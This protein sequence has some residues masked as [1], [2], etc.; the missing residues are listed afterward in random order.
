[1]NL[2]VI[3]FNLRVNNARDGKN[4]WPYRVNKAAKVI[5]SNDPD[6]IGMQE[7][8]YSM[9]ED[10]QDSL[11]AYEMIGEG[12]G[13]GEIDEYSAI[14]YKKSVLDLIDQ[15]QF[16][17]SETPEIANSISWNSACPRICT[18]GK[19]RKITKRSQEFIVFNTHLDHM[20]KEAREKGVRLILAHI[21]QFMK[22]KM[23]VI[24]MGDLNVKPENQVIQ[25]LKDANLIE[26]QTEG[27]TFHDF[28]G[29]IDGEPIDYIFTS[30]HVKIIRVQVDRQM[31]DGSY[32]SD[33]Y[34]VIADLLI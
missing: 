25:M 23:P 6:I 24:F 16:W 31:L 7:A 14:F 33:H 19:F 18:W 17:L 29:G 22:E 10:L 13:G 4:A 34:P 20:S 21:D 11:S 28:Q 8:L 1:M 32:P 2:S 12:R 3:T 27:R 30:K 5:A 26:A 15:G 9:L